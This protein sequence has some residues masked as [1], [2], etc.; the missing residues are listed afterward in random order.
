MFTAVHGCMLA[1]SDSSVEPSDK[2]GCP[3]DS[4]LHVVAAVLRIYGDTDHVHVIAL[5]DRISQAELI[6]FYGEMTRL[7]GPKP[8]GRDGRSIQQ[9][10]GLDHQKE[11]TPLFTGLGQCRRALQGGRAARFSS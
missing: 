6:F 11:K 1:A 7:N 5:E 10:V 3:R 4:G 8:L 2:H 9:T